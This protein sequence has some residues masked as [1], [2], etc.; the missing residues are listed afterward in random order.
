VEQELEEGPGVVRG[1]AEGE[2]V[3]V[4]LK[5]ELAVL[6]GLNPGFQSMWEP[7]RTEFKVRGKS[8]MVDGVKVETQPPL[9]ELLHTELLDVA[10]DRSEAGYPTRAD[11]VVDL[12]KEVRQHMDI[13]G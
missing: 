1:E 12:L 11:H 10:T 3:L 4:M 7:S 6:R 5:E 9:F 8:Y 2:M 13:Y